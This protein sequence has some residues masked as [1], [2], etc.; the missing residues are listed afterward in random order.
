MAVLPVVRGLWESPLAEKTTT[1]VLSKI[2]DILKTIAS[3]D[4]EADLTHRPS[5]SSTTPS[6]LFKRENI[7]FNWAACSTMV[8]RLADEYDLELAREAVYRANVIHDNASEYCRAQKAG[9]AGA[10]NPIP[11]EDLETLRTQPAPE[12]AESRRPTPARTGS[13]LLGPDDAMILDNNPDLDRLLG[14][15]VLSELGERSSQASS[16]SGG[17]RALPSDVQRDSTGTDQAAASTSA[18][19]AASPRSVITKDDLDAEREKLRKDLIDRC[20]D[21]IRAHPDAVFE[22]SELITVAVLRRESEE[23]RQ[24][25]GETLANALMSFAIDDEVKKSSGRSIAAYAH[26]LSLLLQE[27]KFFK[28]TVKTLRDNV[29]EYLGFLKIAPGN[30]TEDLPPWIPYILLIFEI[31]LADDEQLVEAKWKAPQTENDTVEAPVLQPKDSN[32]T[33]E[34]RGV[35]LDAILDILPRVGKDESLAIAILRVLVILTRNRS[36]AKMMGDKKNLQRLFV[37]TKQLSGLGSGRLKEMRISGSILTILRHI[38]EDEETIRQIMRYEIQTYFENPQRNPRSS[39][40]AN[41]LRTLSHVALRSPELFVDVT[42]DMVKLSRWAPPSGDGVP[43]ATNLMLKGPTVT[44]SNPSPPKD[45]SVEPAVQ[46]T[47]DLTIND[48]KPSTEVGDKD[49]IEASKPATGELKRPVLENPDG[50]IHFLLCELLNYREVDDKDLSQSSKEA[51]PSSD[52]VQGLSTASTSSSNEEQSAENKDKKGTKPSF[53]AEEHPIFVYRCF[54]LHCLAELLQ[55]YNR[56]KIEFINFKRSA[57]LLNN[58]PVKPR[59][60]VLNYILNDL[61]CTSISAAPTESLSW[62]KKVATSDLARLTLV[63]LVTKTGEKWV[64]RRRDRFDYND[65]PDLLFVRKFVLDTILRAY[66]EASTPNEPFDVR[67]AKMLSLA[68]LMSAMIGEKDRDPTSTRIADSS[69]LRSQMQLKRL[70]YE[71]GYLA[72]LTSSI[73]DIDLTFPG[74]KR[75]IKY[76]LRVLR[77][78]TSIGIQLS[79]SNILPATPGEI[80]DEE[81]AS[82]S[83]L[84][85]MEDDREETPDLYR[86]SALGMLEPREEDDYSEDSEDGTT[87]PQSVY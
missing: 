22:V 12:Q 2:V 64:D 86:N 8:T 82:A 19:E 40:V 28:S 31:L 74:V 48:V 42:N 66:K 47:E 18:N 59:S 87:F 69:P 68:E 67:Y 36:V 7:H 46:G 29:G 85:D 53:K 54:L 76:I 24:E 23:G 35:L 83:S 57:P 78:L 44:S 17:E 4:Q 21:V 81:I 61:L 11:D 63:A 30:P 60:S 77:V 20:L 73:A 51:K 38:V 34:D 75:T 14:E 50:V 43:R 15:A 16:E 39:D 41:Y 1:Q 27:V 32:V 49:V 6:T 62:K 45:E 25:V 80:A 65:E 84:S 70:M 52:P 26:L 55:S 58:T 79:H 72:A 9:I 5:N 10:R 33:V 37:M 13:D 56:T 3:A 71:K